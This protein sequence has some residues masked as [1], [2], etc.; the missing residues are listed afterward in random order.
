MVFASRLHVAV[1]GSSG[2]IG[3]ALTERL[4]AEGHRV[5]RLVRRPAGPREIT[6]DPATGRLDP[7]Q[8]EGVDAVVHLAGENLGTRWTEGKKARIRGSRIR[9]TRLVSE[10]LTRLERPPQVLISASAIGI[11]GDRGNQVLT[12]T[13]E[14]GDP[15][16]DFL[17]SV[18]IDWEQATGAARQAG[19]RVIHPRFGP[20][21][22]PAG[23]AL[24]KLLLP[25]RL[26]LGGRLG[27]GTQWLSWIALDDVVGAIWHILSTETLRGAVNLTA[28]NPVTN[29]EF[30]GI[31]GR[32][33]GRPT[34][35]PIPA[36]TLRV[37]LG[38]MAER[39]LLSSTRA[40]PQR[41]VESGY[42]FQHPDLEGAL[43]HMLAK[44]R[45]SSFPA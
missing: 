34:A 25:F 35:L 26:G 38:E 31:L 3:R 27:P 23:G 8:L 12:E 16:R 15:A 44:P 6:W 24:R 10:T 45:R 2:L 18:C 33:L 37:A 19:I 40:V 29:R 5:T 7:E 22:S 4:E 28:P 20:V 13:S 17:V 11:Y 1:S 42:Q 36:A 30:T 9:G 21:L 41:L 43:R 32:V 14:P 39:T